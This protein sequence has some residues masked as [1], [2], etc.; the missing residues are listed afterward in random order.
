MNTTATTAP[1]V[2]IL[3]VAASDAHAVA[4]QLIAMML[5]QQGF[6]VVNLGVCTP[7]EEFAEAYR[8]HPQAEAVLI[9]SLNGHAYEDLKDLPELRSAGQLA[10]PIIVGG[11]LSVG[12]HKGP[13]TANRLRALGVDHILD[14]ADEL[15]VLLN[16]L[17]DQRITDRPAR[18]LAAVGS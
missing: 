12:S 13:E 14:S 2:V 10:C 1:R 8:A 3:G 7:L 17:A 16:R 9:G 11:N 15:P 4:N 6:V 5:R 18:E